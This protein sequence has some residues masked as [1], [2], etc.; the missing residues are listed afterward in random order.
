MEIYLLD[1]NLISGHL[2]LYHPWHEP[3]VEF[4]NQGSV[5]SDYLH[6]SCMAIAEIMFGYEVSLSQD[7][8]RKQIVLDGLRQYR[9]VYRID[10][11]TVGC[12]Y[13]IKANLFKDFGREQFGP[14]EFKKIVQLQPE[15]LCDRVTGKSL[16]IQEADLWM[17]AQAAEHDITFVTADSHSTKR[18]FDA[19]KKA[20]PDFKVLVLSK[21]N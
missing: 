2:D 14:K 1:T 8:S 21:H 9:Q 11:H 17:I 13:K 20:F 3:V 10:H 7:P 15:E 12:Y 4:V 5:D 18:V 19:A 16:G 6:I